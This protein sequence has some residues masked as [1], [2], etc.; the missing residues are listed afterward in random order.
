MTLVADKCDSMIRKDQSTEAER[1]QECRILQCESLRSLER[2]IQ[3]KGTI[4]LK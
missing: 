4:D 3:G 2:A 1:G